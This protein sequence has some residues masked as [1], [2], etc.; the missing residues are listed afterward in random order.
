ME[1]VL[2][3]ANELIPK[4]RDFH[5]E[6]ERMVHIRMHQP[7]FMTLSM[8]LNVLSLNGKSLKPYSNSN[9]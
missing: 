9:C 5:A 2:L 6:L 3:G 8:K 4:A 7:E 1:H